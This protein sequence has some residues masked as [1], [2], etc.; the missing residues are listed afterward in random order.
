M[1]EKKRFSEVVDW[2]TH[3]EPYRIIQFVAGVGSGKNH[4]VENVLMNQMKVLLVTSRKAKVE[5]TSARLSIGKK[6]NFNKL[7]KDELNYF[8]TQNREDGSCVCNNWQIE[9]YMKNKF[10]AD[11]PETYLWNFFDAIVIDEVH[12]L[13]TDATYADAPF[14]MFDFIRA[15]YKCSNKKIILM[16]ATF[17]PIRGLLNFKP[18][19][20]YAFWDVTDKCRNLLPDKL[21]F[22]TT[23]TTLQEI[24]RS[25]Q[26]SEKAKERGIVL[27]DSRWLYFATRTSTIANHIV[28][29]LVESGIPESI[30]AVSFSNDDAVEKFSP[31]VLENKTRTEEYLKIKEDIP[32][33]IKILITTSRNKEGINIDNK[34]CYWN[35]AIESHWTD[36]AAQMWG[37]IRHGLN[38]HED[39]NLPPTNKVVIV[40]DAPQHTKTY[41]DFE[42]KGILSAYCLD[43]VNKT[44][45]LMCSQQEIP[46]KN[47]Y[48]DKSAKRRIEDITKE[49]PY[50]RYSILDNKFRIYRGKVLGERSYTKSLDNFD[51][52]VSG[53]KGEPNG[54]D[55]TPPFSIK[56]FLIFPSDCMESFEEHIT[57]KGFING[58][59]LS[60]Q[61]QI[62]L[63]DFISN[64]LM[65]RKERSSTKKYTSLAKAVHRYGWKLAPNSSKNKHS[66]LYGHA[67]LVRL[68]E[69]PIGGVWD[70]SI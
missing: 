31:I 49:F 22:Q 68:S 50:L 45:N 10:H 39:E 52:Y 56:S 32:E 59:Y 47:R 40:Y 18:P 69:E 17:E 58:K 2:N 51:A 11:E 27:S 19:E 64:T 57:K 66:P 23:E 33:D 25:Y 38:Q 54:M 21:W 60:K 12:S 43:G 46:A 8:W 26:L 44:F 35:V 3:I 55:G 28:P 34:N 14:Y 13:A 41:C 7:Q 1:P 48:N 30:I 36:E 62:E 9:Y 53:W 4:W 65:L 6:L 15:V 29:Y 24:V 63:L 20:N 42:Y 61:E 5:E 67:K 37:R 70:D 16:T